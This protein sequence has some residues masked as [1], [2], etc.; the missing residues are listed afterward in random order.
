[1]SIP[2]VG[3]SQINARKILIDE[4]FLYLTALGSHPRKLS[5]LM[6][7]AH[8]F[9]DRASSVDEQNSTHI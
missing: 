1:M 3:H 4:G 7:N 6:L 2:I 5:R 9:V 8:F